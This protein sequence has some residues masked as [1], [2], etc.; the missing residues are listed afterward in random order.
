MQSRVGKGGREEKGE[1]K[2]EGEKKER[3]INRE[4]NLE[5]QKDGQKT[6]NGLI[7]EHLQDIPEA[8]VSIRIAGVAMEILHTQG[9]AVK[10]VRLFKP[11]DPFPEEVE[12]A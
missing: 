8:D 1:E 2:E 11:T 6:L 4:S 5:Q 10:S 9:R 3:E 7:L 12:A